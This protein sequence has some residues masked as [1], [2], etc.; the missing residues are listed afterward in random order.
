[1][2]RMQTG[3]DCVLR[4]SGFGQQRL[5]AEVKARGAAREVSRK[6]ICKLHFFLDSGG[7]RPYILCVLN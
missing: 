3:G 6:K 7:A 2:E 5:C 4:C 1:M